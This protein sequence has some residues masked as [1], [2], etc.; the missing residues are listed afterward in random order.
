LRASDDAFKDYRTYCRFFLFRDF[1][2]AAFTML[3]VLF[4]SIFKGN[5]GRMSDHQLQCFFNSY[6]EE[7]D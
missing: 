2:R 5:G 4:D 6:A 3:P 7:A 1:A